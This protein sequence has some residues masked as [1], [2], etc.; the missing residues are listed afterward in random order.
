[1]KLKPLVLGFGI[2][3]T[4]NIIG[5]EESA[6]TENEIAMPSEQVEMDFSRRKISEYSVEEAIKKINLALHKMDKKLTFKEIKREAINDNENMITAEI[7]DYL[8]MALYEDNDTKKLKS[9][10]LIMIGDGSVDIAIV[11]ASLVMALTDNINMAPEQRGEVLMKLG[12]TDNSLFE[13]ETKYLVQDDV[14]FS[15]S[16]NKTL[17]GLMINAR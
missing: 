11:S 3:L 13:G 9:I 1:M 2:L 16:L 17:G 7:N 10:M 12:F 4:L 8:A 14:E 15:A 6:N 5:C